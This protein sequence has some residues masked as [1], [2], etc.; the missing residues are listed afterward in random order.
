M[1][2]RSILIVVALVLLALPALADE[3]PEGKVKAPEVTAQV[4]QVEVGKE[5]LAENLQPTNGLPG[6]GLEKT[7]E[8]LVEQDTTCPICP[9][10]FCQRKNWRCDYTGCTTK[11]CS[12]NC[13]Y[14]TSCT[15]GSCYP[16]ACQCRILPL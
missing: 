7:V 1:R 3:A 15:S 9:L 2:A 16:Y 4:P 8:P 11:C 6:L 5:P 10:S 14:D 12:Y 13:Y